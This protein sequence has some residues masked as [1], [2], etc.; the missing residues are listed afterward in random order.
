MESEIYVSDCQGIFSSEVSGHF[1]RTEDFKTKEKEVVL[2][3]PDFDISSIEDLIHASGYTTE[4]IVG[5]R[6]TI[7]IEED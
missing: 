6:V 4:S 2:A 3:V 5:K 7:R 1:C